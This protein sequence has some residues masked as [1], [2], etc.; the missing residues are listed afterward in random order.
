[1]HLFGRW[2]LCFLP[3]QKMTNKCSSMIGLSF[4][5]IR[6]EGIPSQ[7]IKTYILNSILI[8]RYS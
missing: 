8:S 4:V 7:Q 6:I 1:M 2:P 5:E 3:S